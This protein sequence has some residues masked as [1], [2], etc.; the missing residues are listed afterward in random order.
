MKTRTVTDEILLP[1]KTEEND[2]HFW[3][4]QL[5]APVQLH[6]LLQTKCASSFFYN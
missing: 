1:K 2:K 6:S 4:T 3:V 5:E